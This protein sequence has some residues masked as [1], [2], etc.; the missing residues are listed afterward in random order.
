MF[1]PLHTTPALFV[2]P[3]RSRMMLASA[4]AWEKLG[5]RWLSTLSGVVMIEAGKQ[6][7]AASAAREAARPRRVYAPLPP[8]TP[9]P[10]G[11]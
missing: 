7:Y 5:Q 2:P 9:A 6:I 10:S 8:A 4:P 11:G 3:S 1:A